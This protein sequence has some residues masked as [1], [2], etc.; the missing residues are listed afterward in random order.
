MKESSIITKERV[1]KELEECPLISGLSL[2][3]TLPK[4]DEMLSDPEFHR[5]A[6]KILTDKVRS[7]HSLQGDG[8][9]YP[10]SVAFR[11]RLKSWENLLREVEKGSQGP[12]PS[13]QEAL[14]NLENAKFIHNMH[15]KISS[16]HF[17]KMLGNHAFTTK[18]EDLIQGKIKTLEAGVA[19]YDNAA[20][21]LA[22]Q[23]WQEA[24]AY[25]EEMKP[26]RTR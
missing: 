5:S 2:R 25:I 24:L 14:G 23:G 3:P 19:V 21:S 4:F 10:G 16:K 9:R 15:P 13:V 1:L 11:H 22:L 26:S 20:A 6:V 17:K 8:N 12:S 7:L 18:A